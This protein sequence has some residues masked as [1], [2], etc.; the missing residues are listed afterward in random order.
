LA[1]SAAA[2]AFALAACGQKGPLYLPS[3]A[4]GAAK[5][6]A[7]LPSAP[8]DGRP[9]APP[10]PQEGASSPALPAAAK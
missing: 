7:R 9:V 1:A 8:D 3:Q 4:G 6:V 5:P 2:L 10:A